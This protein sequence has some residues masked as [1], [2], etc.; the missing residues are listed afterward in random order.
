M[1]M[2]GL[3]EPPTLETWEDALN[4]IEERRW[5]RHKAS[6][7][8]IE[9]GEGEGGSEPEGVRAEVENAEVLEQETS[10]LRRKEKVMR[11][12][13]EVMVEAMD[14]DQQVAGMVFDGR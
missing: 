12:I 13:E 8:K 11:L 7:Y 3:S 5:L 4:P 9:A 1:V 10:Q 2:H 14:D 6:I